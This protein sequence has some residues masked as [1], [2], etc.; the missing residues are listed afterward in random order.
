[1]VSEPAVTT[2]TTPGVLSTFL[3]VIFCPEQ[4]VAE[5]NGSEIPL[6]AVTRIS[7]P[8][9]PAN[10]RVWGVDTRCTESAVALAPLPEPGTFDIGIANCLLAKPSPFSENQSTFS[11]QIGAIA[12]YKLRAHADK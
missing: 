2:V 10:P 5:T 8:R 11:V 7:V 6:P 4:V 12:R 9:V 1:M 3:T